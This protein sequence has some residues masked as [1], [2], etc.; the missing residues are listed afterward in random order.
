MVYLVTLQGVSHEVWN[1]PFLIEGDPMRLQAFDQEARSLSQ[2]AHRDRVEKADVPPM[3]CD[4]EVFP[5][6]LHES[7]RPAVRV[8]CPDD[9]KTPLAQNAMAFLH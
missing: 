7:S 1:L 5:S 4:T 9:E 3:F 2:F 6:I 8:S